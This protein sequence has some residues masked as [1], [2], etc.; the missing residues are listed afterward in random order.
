M[1]LFLSLFLIVL[2]TSVQPVSSELDRK[3]VVVL[4][5]K[6]REERSRLIEQGIDILS[7]DLK[8]GEVKALVDEKDLSLLSAG[9]IKAESFFDS[10]PLTYPGEDQE[11]HDY[12]ELTE[13]LF[14]LQNQYPHLIRVFSIG[15]TFEGRDIWAV[16]LGTTEDFDY[17]SVIFLGGHHARE[18]LSVEVALRHLKM[19]TETLGTGVGKD[20]SKLTSLFSERTAYFVPLVNPDGAE[21][22][23]EGGR[24]KMWRKNRFPNTNGTF[25]VDLNRNYGFQWATGGSSAQPRSDVYH[26]THGFSEA[27]TQSVR[28]FVESVQGATTVLSYHTFSELILYPWGHTYDRIGNR[29]DHETHRLLARR[30]S[31]WNDYTPQQA[32]D[33]YIASGDTCD[34]AYGELGKICFTFELDPS[35]SWRGGFYP[36]ARIINSVVEKNREPALFLLEYADDPRR[37][38]R[39]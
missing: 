13:A 12:A 1:K 6:T 19:W 7:V 27:E 11:F 20:H 37:I 25:G 2:V 39:E 21:F 33:L 32:S 36:G 9:K 29:E 34:W 15:Q 8:R 28:D 5:A 23:I 31:R 4:E 18:H 10:L 22:D 24:Y 30:M 35:S 17:P 38:L 16:R 14:E 26:G 3:K